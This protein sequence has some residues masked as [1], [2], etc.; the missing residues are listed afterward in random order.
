MKPFVFAAL[1]LP[2]G[3][4]LSIG[5]HQAPLRY[6]EPVAPPQIPAE[7]AK[8]TAPVAAFAALD[9]F[10]NK[11]ARCHGKYGAN[12]GDSLKTRDDQSLRAI[13]H[14]MAHGPA[15][16]PIEQAQLEVLTAWHRSLIDGKPFVSIV[17]IKRDGETMTLAGEATPDAVVS[18]IEGEKE[19]VATRDGHRW[20]AKISSDLA[21]LCVRAKVGE[22][23]SEIAPSQA[24]FSHAMKK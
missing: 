24:M 2:I 20:T 1:L 7:A 6:F 8:D 21:K 10:D 23:T 14:D 13:V 3:L 5:S 12:Y 17:E 16:A 11:C 9:Y 22:A 15:Q 19:I 4:A 18:V